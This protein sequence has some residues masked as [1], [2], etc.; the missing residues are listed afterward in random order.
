MNYPLI[1]RKNPPA[2]TQKQRFAKLRSNGGWKATTSERK[3]L[4]FR[5][6][7]L[8]IYWCQLCWQGI[9]CLLDR[10]VSFQNA[11]EKPVGDASTA[12]QLN[13][14][15]KNTWILCTQEADHC[16]NRIFG[17]FL[18]RDCRLI[19]CLSR[20]FRLWLPFVPVSV[21]LIGNACSRLANDSTIVGLEH[22]WFSHTCTIYVHYFHPFDWLFFQSHT[23]IRFGELLTLQWAGHAFL[24]CK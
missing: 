10:F 6:S 17:R 21:L 3:D 4:L 16:I 9:L 7:M 15:A 13:T 5:G 20:L 11:K 24:G 12:D 19:W 23:A 22:S 1:S 2:L 8:E 14:K 18:R